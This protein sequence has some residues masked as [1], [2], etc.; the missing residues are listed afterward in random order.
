MPDQLEQYYSYLKNAGADVPPSFE[1]FRTTLSDEKSASQYYT[2]L[3]QNNFDAPDTFESFANTIGLKKKEVSQPP[4]SGQPSSVPSPSQ[5]QLPSVE[6]IDSRYFRVQKGTEFLNNIL[7]EKKKFEPNTQV[8]DFIRTAY[9]MNQEG[10]GAERT[11]YV[12]NFLKNNIETFDDARKAFINST[13]SGAYFSE[14]PSLKSEYE[15]SEF[16][17][18]V[19]PRQFTG[20]K[21][22]SYGKQKDFDKYVEI[23]KTGNDTDKEVAKLELEKIGAEIDQNA[24]ASMIKQN[25]NNELATRLFSESK[26]KAQ[27]ADEK[28]RQIDLENPYSYRS[29]KNI[30]NNAIERGKVSGE[31]ASILNVTSDVTGID[32]DELADLQARQQ[33]ARASKAYE[34]FMSDMSF[35]NF[36]KNPIGILTEMSLESLVALYT[37]GASRMATGAATGAAAGSVV[38]GIGTVSGAATG[39]TAG[40]GISS[41]NLEYSGK[42]LESLR[43]M[44]VDVTNAKQLKDS[45]ANAELM[46]E[47]KKKGFQKGVPVMLLDMISMGVAGKIVTKPTTTVLGKAL[48]GGAEMGVQGV[49][50]GTGEALGQVTSEGKVN[51]WNDVV[52]EIIGETGPG[53]VQIVTGAAIESVKK[54]ATDKKSVVAAAKNPEVASKII[55]TNIGAGVIS[56]ED[57]EKL[58]A[59][60]FETKKVV[61]KIPAEVADENKVEIIDLIKEKESLA[62]QKKSLDPAFH[63]SIDEKIKAVDIQIAEVAARP[64]QQQTVRYNNEDWVIEKDNGD[65]TVMLAKRGGP[66]GDS[67]IKVRKDF[68]DQPTQQPA[69]EPAKP[70]LADELKKDLGIDEEVKTSVQES[71]KGLPVKVVV[72][73]DAEV[74]DMAKRLG[75]DGTERAFFNDQTGEIV[76]REGAEDIDIIHEGAHPALNILFNTNRKQYDQVVAGLK[77]AAGKNEGVAAAVRFGQ[78]YEGQAVQDNEALTESIAMIGTGQIDLNTID[79]GFKQTLIDFVNKIAKVLGFEPVLGDTDTAAFKKL[80]GDIANALKS[81]T[82]ITKVVGE[83][84]VENNISRA[85]LAPRL[86][87]IEIDRGKIESNVLAATNDIK[88]APIESETGVTFNLDGTIFIGQGLIVPAASMNT[89]Q[90]ELSPKMVADFIESNKGKLS[91]GEMFKVGYYKFPN[92]NQVSIDLNIV[93]DPK[94]NKTAIEFGK[95][96]GQE[97]LYDLGSNQNIKT[98]AD[99]SSPRQFTDEEFAQIAVD[100]KAGKLPSFIKNDSAKTQGFFSDVVKGI[101][102]KYRPIREW[103]P[104]LDFTP[105]QEAFKNIYDKYLGNFDLHIAT[106]IPTFRETQVKVGN[107]IVQMFPNGGLVYDIGGSE[108]GFVKSITESSGGKI[109]TINLDPNPDMQEIH[110]AKPVAGSEFIR[111]AFYEGF[112]DNGIT[113]VAHK[114][115]SKADVVHESMVFQFITPERKNYIK[116]VKDKYLKGDGLFITE[117][118]VSQDPDVYAANEKKKAEYKDLYYT[119]EQQ[120]VK[121]DD[122]LVGMKENQV[123]LDVFKK[124]L[125]DNFKYVAQYWDSG[126]FKGFVASDSKQKIDEFLNTVGSTESE[127]TTEQLPNNITSEEIPDVVTSGQMRIQPRKTDSPAVNVYEQKGVDQLPV[128]S[129]SDIYS[130]FGGRAVVINSDPTRVGELTLPSGKKIFTYGGPGYLS[131]SDNVSGNVGFATTK[132]SKV[133]SWNKY[134]KD[135]FGDEKGVTLVATQTPMSMLGNSYALRYVM[136]AISQLP[137]SVLRSSDFKSE[138]FGKDLGMLKEAFGEKG[139]N[140][141]VKKYKGADLSNPEVI[142]GMISEMAYKIG[143]DNRPASFKARGAFV[144][145][146]LGGIVEKSNRKGMEGQAGYISKDPNKFIAKELM[147]RF[148]LNQEKLFYELGEKSIVDL[149]M[150]EGKW[151]MAVAGFETDPNT[152][153]ESVQGNGVKHPLFNAK[154][155]GSNPFILDGAYELNELFTAIEMT[156]PSGAPYTK[157]AAMMTAGSMYV[158][159]T[160]QQTETSFEFRESDAAGDR[161]QFRKGAENSREFKLAAF[162]IRKKAEGVS[163]QEIESAIQSVMPSMSAQEIANIVNNPEQFIRDTFKY[164]SPS[165][166]QNLINR[167]RVTNMYTRSKTPVDPAFASLEVSESDVEEFMKRKKER[168][169]SWFGD[170]KRKWFD[171]AQGFPG[172]VLAVRDITKGVKDLEIRKA[173]DRVSDLK[174]VAE[175]IGFTDW[176]AFSKAMTSLSQPT[177]E[178]SQST[179]IQPW[180]ANI[181]AQNKQLANPHAVI[182]AEIAALPEEIR[183]FVYQMRGTID[184]LSDELVGSGFVTPEQAVK[185]TE[186]LGQYVNRA[187][188]LFNEKGYKPSEEAV[189]DA[190][191]FLTDKY[192]KQLASENAGVMTYEEVKEKALEMADREVKSI[193]N[194]QNVKRQFKSDTRDTSILK[195]RQ[196]IPAPIRKLMGEYTDPGTVFVMTVAKQAALRSASQYL[197]AL[198]LN[199]LG[200]IFFEEN[201]PNRPA[202]FSVK[203]AG[204]NS[205]TKSPLNGLYTTPEIAEAIDG[206]SPTLNDLTNAWMKVVG[207]V[208]WGKTVG[209]V[210]TQLKNFESNIGFAVMN[211]LIFSGKNTKALQGAAKYFK[212]QLS[213]TELDDLT[214]KVMALGLVNQSVGA[215]ELRKMLGSGDIHDI[216]VE[217]AVTGKSKGAVNWLM[218]PIKGLNKMYQLSDD[219]WKVYAYMN[220]R[221]LV[222]KAMYGEKYDAITPEEQVQVDL[223]ASERV[224]NTLPT[225]DRVWAGAKYV[226]ERAPIFGN[227]ISFQAE[228]VRVF[229]NTIKLAFKDIRSGNPEFAALGYK[230]LAGIISYVGLRT[231]ITYAAAQAAGVGM[232]GLIGAFDD[233]EEKD[234]E[235]ALRKAL[236]QFMRTGDLLAIKQK[237]PSKFTVFDLSSIDP[238]GVV[239]KSLNALTEGREGVFSE[240]MEPGV[241]AALAEFFSGFLEPEM[242]FK[243]FMDLYNNSNAK[244]GGKIIKEDQ[245]KTQAFLEAGKYVADQLKPSTIGLAQRLM[246]PTPEAELGSA[247]G[248]RPYE[249]DLHRSFGRVMSKVGKDLEDVVR[250]YNA[251]K[252]NKELT[253]EERNEAE[254]KAEERAA[255][256]AGKLSETYNQFLLLGADKKTL[257]EMIKNK[258]QVKSTGFSKAFKK[259]IKTGEINPDKYFK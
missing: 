112:E 174:K 8:S 12:Y 179:G 38:P 240:T 248:A 214:Q 172:W 118:K 99:G 247:F 29:F 143:D 147:K 110:E 254:K 107:A 226:S 1:S 233:E 159:G 196:D 187:Y 130:Q 203:I 193:I 183:P 171:A 58:K 239:F 115:K 217:L 52:A 207:A 47:L 45:F 191:K 149:F 7:D 139:Y 85:N 18:Q 84:S 197:T 6:E 206:I 182:P 102:E 86:S 178:L 242:T 76:L 219:F 227:F 244:T 241:P 101:S 155:P 190:M 9:K 31:S 167:A 56:K 14:S 175:Q 74:T 49:L 16:K 222:S 19:S 152:S 173:T 42:I 213:K 184:N 192:I 134:V 114:P 150:N 113:Y 103:T 63:P 156:G 36:S 13:Y 136:D 170:F 91:D 75:G 50:G 78:Q 148:G 66:G 4:V 145:N 251:A 164:L 53:S 11:D 238:Y 41:L 236:P 257:D 202:E 237:D 27:E 97:S 246:G 88:S 40:L 111:E 93:V 228:V 210:V 141:F 54:G 199:G 163:N 100:L 22:L 162:V 124:N 151:G 23:L 21:S 198:R 132:I 108:G 82:D 144:S 253:A 48:A 51:S 158:K 243:T 209:S 137:K 80:A 77:A 30:I 10:R 215:S 160:P 123:S 55:D 3:R 37:H 234:K 2:Y 64:V 194:R 26:Q 35:E 180:Y 72:R 129:I 161:I 220:E 32:V 200:T 211:G 154:F 204:D 258:G 208:R 24:S 169:N 119:K 117:E 44:G 105:Q 96:S 28:I 229:N 109:K 133:N 201:D 69:Q 34:N 70:T 176:D 57:G 87:N 120:A 73:P 116:E 218:K 83:G 250:E 68:I 25:V 61:D 89:T 43:E 17:A 39:M 121:T 135:L 126:N 98:G 81:G 225:Y 230:R 65:G 256:Y 20:L 104:L 185:L 177:Q 128:R 153:I 252:Y 138:F 255:Y 165:L 59:E 245:T 231:V 15:K 189:A 142:D 259:S 127:F 92:S 146:L 181:A 195:E 62:E 212:G 67:L 166:Q 33:E 46:S 122:V 140:E 249:V 125:E 131:I 235:A 60:I 186:N 221:E 188:R 5:S 224:K 168:D 79:P 223:E 232:A 90:E 106:S 71:L 216:A 94:N 205:D 157:T 95:L